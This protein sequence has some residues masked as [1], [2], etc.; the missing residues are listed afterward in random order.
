MPK[1]KNAENV[2]KYSIGPAQQ[3]NMRERIAA[4]KLST[5]IFYKCLE[6]IIKDPKKNIYKF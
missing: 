1:T 6:L 4:P 2:V 5:L 3:E